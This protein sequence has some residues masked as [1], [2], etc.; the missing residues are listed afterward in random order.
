VLKRFKKYVIKRI[1][2]IL[3]VVP[4]Y[5]CNAISSAEQIRQLEGDVIEKAK[6][7]LGGCSCSSWI[8]CTTLINK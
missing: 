5:L 7:G 6:A 8:R 2:L 1:R 4:D 3:S